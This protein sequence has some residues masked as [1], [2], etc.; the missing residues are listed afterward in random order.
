MF[1]MVKLE[2]IWVLLQ[3]RVLLQWRKI[4]E[5]HWLSFTMFLHPLL[6]VGFVSLWGQWDGVC[7]QLR[8]Y[9]PPDWRRSASLSSRLFGERTW[10][11]P[12]AF[13]RFLLLG[14]CGH[15]ADL[16]KDFSR[17]VQTKTSERSCLIQQ[18]P[19]STM[20]KTALAN[21]SSSLVWSG[22]EKGIT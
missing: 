13:S 11:R 7:H 8:P 20:Q 18:D 17:H 19:V 12:R 4:K 6:V 10:W 1:L 3:S 16:G 2:G 9:W 22:P 14:S 5:A 21:C 15:D